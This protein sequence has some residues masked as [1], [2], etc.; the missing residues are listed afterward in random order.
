MPLPL[1]LDMAAQRGR[2]RKVP[3]EIHLDRDQLAIPNGVQLAVA[4]ALCRRRGFIDDERPFPDLGSLDDDRRIHRLAVRPA[5]REVGRPVERVVDRTGEAKVLGKQGL[6]GGAVLGNI[7][8]Q[9]GAG[10]S[11]EGS[12]QAPVQEIGRGWK[13]RS[14]ARQ[15]AEAS[16]QLGDEE[17]GNLQLREVPVATQFVPIE[18]LG[19]D[20]GRP[21]A[22]RRQ[23]VRP[24]SQT[25]NESE[26]IALG[27]LKPRGLGAA[28]DDGALGTALARD[29]V[30]TLENDAALP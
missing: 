14:T 21:T 28:A 20:E 8:L 27:I 19:V 26:N 29:V 23:V 24:Q 5:A 3:A 18:K 9:A 25:L 22:R 4:K 16:A 1:V 6:D 30:V 15:Q 12:W 17:I 13:R 2:M 10:R 11:R 7:S